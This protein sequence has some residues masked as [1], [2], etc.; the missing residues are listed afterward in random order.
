[1]ESKKL[2]FFNNLSFGILLFTIFASFIFFMPYLPVTLEASKGFLVSIG[3]TLSIFFWF[4]VRLGEGKFVIPKDRLIIL[5]AVIPFIFLISSFFSSSLYVS[6][7]G[8]GFEVGTFGSMLIL[9][10]IFFLSAVHFQT[11]NKLKTF[12]KFLMITAF[13]ITIFQLIN[14]TIGFGRFLPGLLQGVSSGNLL[15]SWNDFALMFGLFVL[16][17]IFSIDLLKSKLIYRIIQYFVLVLGILFLI[18][19]NMPLVWLLV[20]LFGVILFV[21][22]ISAGHSHSSSEQESNEKPHANGFPVASLVL[23]IISFIFI[24]GSNSIGNLISNY[25]SLS[26]PDVRPSFITTSQIAY[27][28]IKHNP[29]LGTGP[30]TFVIDW[31]MWKPAQISN[32]LFW[33]IDFNS[34]FS[35][36]T[37][38]FATVGVLG[39]LSILAFLFVFIIRIIQSLKIAFKDGVLNYFI[40]TTLMVSLY[41]WIIF[42]IYNP[43]ILM[44]ILAFSSSG[45]L[46]GILIYKR[47]IPTNEASF[48]NDPRNSFFSILFLVVLMMSSISLTYVYV[49]KFVSLIYYSKGV[50]ANVNDIDSLSKSE[51]MISNAIT[52]DKNDSYYRSL[53][54][55]YVNEI[56][57][58]ANNKNLSEDTL[59]SSLQQLVNL[60]QE[61]A[62]LA[63]SR[64]PKNYLNYINLGDV[65]T[66]LV[67]FGVE[68][69][70]ENALSSYNKALELAPNNPSI[71]LSMANLEFINKNNDKAKEYIKNALTLKSNYID[72]IFLMAQIE[73]AEG[74]LGEAIK[75]AEYASQ[76][77][78]NDSTI[79]FRLGLLR[80]NNSDYSGAVSAFERAVILNNNYLNARYFLGLSYQKVGRKSDALTQFEILNK[81]VPENEEIKNALNSVN[82]NTIT[83]TEENED[84]NKNTENK[85]PLKENQ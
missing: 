39:A 68:N 45:I 60:S 20:G 24:I 63:V 11:E 31:T 40:M 57:L 23:V 7:F 85:P 41:S 48:L 61:S 10:I 67:V 70:Y 28:A 4:V 78:P 38:L 46:I 53:S 82:N 14:F 75:Q 25:I 34:G 3:A 56:S 47:V 44:L 27:K 55:V 21:Y 79:F 18:I 80:Y 2:K 26:S 15:G 58:V 16:L 83:E 9:Y 19:I 76:I 84:T 73:T 72:A 49:E 35:M 50:V 71:I 54:Q 1:M 37:T 22:N 17:S 64:N 12:F 62:T 8:N 59:K 65:Y 6:L 74:N 29:F 77:N 81:L 36:F 69:S 51:V 43:N 33:D 13:V 52:L 32:T 5:G 66:S 42:I 30:N